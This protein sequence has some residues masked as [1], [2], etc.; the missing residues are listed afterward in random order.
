MS[1]KN[2]YLLKWTGD[3]V[4]TGQA[5]PGFFPPSVILANGI[6]PTNTSGV[7][8]QVLGASAP[9]VSSSGSVSS[10]LVGAAAGGLLATGSANLLG[11]SYAALVLT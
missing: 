4:S 11:W 8:L 3:G 10:D 7:Q 6:D 5:V 2:P 1:D 9:C